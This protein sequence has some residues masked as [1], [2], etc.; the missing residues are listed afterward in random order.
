MKHGLGLNKIMST[1]HVYPT[2]SE[3][4]KYTAGQWKQKHKPEKLLA[5]VEKYHRFKRK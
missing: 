1:I 5:W 3:A 4:N 2:H